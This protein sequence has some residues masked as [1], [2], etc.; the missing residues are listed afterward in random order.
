MSMQLK[1][2]IPLTPSQRA[3]KLGLPSSRFQGK[4]MGDNALEAIEKVKKRDRSGH[5]VTHLLL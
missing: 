2:V 4:T 1:Q 3:Q 5:K